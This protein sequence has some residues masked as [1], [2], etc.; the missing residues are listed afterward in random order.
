MTF[1]PFD[2]AQSLDQREVDR[3]ARAYPPDARF[4]PQSVRDRWFTPAQQAAW[5]LRFGNQQ[6]AA[7]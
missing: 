7:R 2:S 3:I 1:R 6:G 4:T 5:D